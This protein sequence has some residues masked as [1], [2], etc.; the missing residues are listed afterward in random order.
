MGCISL[1]LVRIAVFIVSEVS[2]LVSY[3]LSTALSIG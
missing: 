1:Q 3:A 2:V